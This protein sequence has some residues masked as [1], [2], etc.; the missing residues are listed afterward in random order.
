[1]RILDPIDQ[2]LR[3]HLGSDPGEAGP[4][5]LETL[6]AGDQVATVTTE[7]LEKL[8]PLRDIR[9]TIEI[10]DFAVAINTTRLLLRPPQER[11]EPEGDIPMGLFD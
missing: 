3:V 4:N 2:P 7:L 1:M 5:F 6:V 10:D 9:S 11:L 8:F